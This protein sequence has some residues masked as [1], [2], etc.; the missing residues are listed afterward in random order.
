[1]DDASEVVFGSHICH[2]RELSEVRPRGRGVIEISMVGK[3]YV[4]LPPPIPR[5]L[6]LLKLLPAKMTNL[7]DNFSTLQRKSHLCIPRKGSARPQSPIYTFICLW[8]I[9]IFPGSVHIFSCGRIGRE[10]VGITKKIAHRNMNV[11]IRTEAAQFLF[12][13]HLF[14]IFSIVS[15]V[16][17]L[18]FPFLW[19]YCF[20]VW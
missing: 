4:H 6:P 18:Q 9:Y 10:I 1:M 5:S 15:F 16:C 17:V 11:E 13:E 8:A 2:R 19:C 20:V 3:S 7:K 12:W 14:G